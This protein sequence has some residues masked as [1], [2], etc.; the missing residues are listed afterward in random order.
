MENDDHDLKGSSLPLLMKQSTEDRDDNAKPDLFGGS[1][2]ANL[3]S[4][5]GKLIHRDT[6]RNVHAPS[7]D[8]DCLMSDATSELTSQTY[9]RQTASGGDV[10]SYTNLSSSSGPGSS[11][12]PSV[13]ELLRSLTGLYDVL[14]DL[15][16]VNDDVLAKAFS[17]FGTMSDARVMR[18][19]ISEK[20]YGYGFLAFVDKTDAEQAIATM[21]GERLGSRE[22][23]VNWTNQETRRAPPTTTASSR[24]PITS[25]IAPG[26]LEASSGC[27]NEKENLAT[28]I[29]ALNYRPDFAT[30]GST[31]PLEGFLGTLLSDPEDNTSFPDTLPYRKRVAPAKSISFSQG[32]RKKP[33]Y[34]KTVASAAGIKAS[35]ARRNKPAKFVC[36]L[37]KQ[38]FTTYTNLKSKPSSAD[39]VAHE[40]INIFQ[41][42]SMFTWT[43]RTTR[44]A[45]QRHL[46]TCKVPSEPMQQ[47]SR[48]ED[49]STIEI[50]GFTS[51]AV[52]ASEQF[53]RLPSF[54]QLL[55]DCPLSPI[56]PVAVAHPESSSAFPSN[57]S[58]SLALP[59]PPAETS[60]ALQELATLPHAH[61]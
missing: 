26:F 35:Q 48:H 24:R 32:R 41:T 20:H 50:E 34:L 10:M 45:L 25:G 28:G 2:K 8:E 16:Q 21:N 53:C 3:E 47:P 60:S 43:L 17:A 31:D 7:N 44:A 39:V 22:I 51:D 42:T 4:L 30:S 55:S 19:K 13:R 56:T 33:A 46:K 5:K 54:A 27:G 9:E 52:T 23:R 14:G 38:T 18:D 57:P 37:C 36:V 29:D 15:I 61:A 1:A 11:H 40:L 49:D 59:T 12:L 58:G 6:Q